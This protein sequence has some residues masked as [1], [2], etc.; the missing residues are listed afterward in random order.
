MSGLRERHKEAT[1]RKLEESALHLY[2]VNGF[3]RTTIDDLC[4]HAEVG[5]RTF[6]RYFD[7]KEDVL[8]AR[9]RIDVAALEETFRTA[10]ASERTDDLLLRAVDSVITD[11][12][13]ARRFTEVVLDEPA[14]RTLFLGMLLEVEE[15]LAA[16]IARHH[17]PGNAQ[18]ARLV[19]AAAV[20]GYRVGLRTW[21]DGPADTDPKPIIRRDVLALA[22][23]L[24]EERC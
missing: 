12:E 23:P 19:A 7:S 18:S 16:L 13:I 1:R 6:F 11:R 14:L 2:R 5:R 24:I 10:D 8:L 4:G 20:T 15:A 17:H 21:I 22:G 9:L 3:R